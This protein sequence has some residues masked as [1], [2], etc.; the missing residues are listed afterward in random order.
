MIDQCDIRSEGGFSLA[1]TLR[2]AALAGL[3]AGTLSPPAS[4]AY[5]G[6][7]ARPAAGFAIEVHYSPRAGA[8]MARRGESLSIAVF[9]GGEPS[10]LGRRHAAEDGTI[11]LGDEVLTVSGR[12]QRVAISGRS[13]RADR[14]SWV[15][16]GAR[17]T[18]N[19]Y[20]ARRTSRDNFLDCGLIEGPIA[21]I[22]GSTQRVHCRLLGER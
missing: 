7:P 2:Y 15:Q 10:R 3:A 14:L 4:A 19:L 9:Y 8:E 16:G 11:A 13:F 18:V 1:R 5:A 6:P 22:A 12:P 21:Q 17:V 20:S